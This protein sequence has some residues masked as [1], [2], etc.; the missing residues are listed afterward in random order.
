MKS[1]PAN[2]S[3]QVAG[4]IAAFLGVV[5]VQMIVPHFQEVFETFGAELPAITRFF[6]QGRWFLWAVPLAVP[7]IAAFVRVRDENDRRRGIVGLIVGIAIGFGLTLLC[8]IAMYLPISMS[9]QTA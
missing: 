4:T 9:A 5:A 7:M 3:L 2:V 1:H 6:V 8:G